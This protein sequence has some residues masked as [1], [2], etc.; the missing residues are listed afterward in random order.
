MEKEWVLVREDW[1]R[2]TTKASELYRSHK[3]MLFFFFFLLLIIYLKGRHCACLKNI[4]NQ[5]GRDHLWDPVQQNLQISTF[6]AQG[7]HVCMVTL[8]LSVFLWSSYLP[9]R[10]WGPRQRCISKYYRTSSSGRALLIEDWSSL[11]GA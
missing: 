11:R 10:W 4:P 8:L 7:L 1:S 2:L 5:P 3:D 9:W 6:V